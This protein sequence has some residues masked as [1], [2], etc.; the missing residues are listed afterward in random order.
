M[1]NYVNI[2]KIMNAGCGVGAAHVGIPMQVYRITDASNGDFLSD[3]N[4]LFQVF[5]DRAKMKRQDPAFE[6]AERM[7]TFWFELLINANPLNV[8]DILISTDPYLNAGSVVINGATDQYIG[9]CLAA[10][11][12][13][14]HAIAARL[15]INATLYRPSITPTPTDIGAGDLPYFDSTLPV[16]LPIVCINGQ[17]QL[18]VLTDTAS[19]IP[20]GT[21]PMNNFGAIFHNS[22][23][24]MPTQERRRVYV[25]PLPGFIP[26][27]GD[28]LVT[29]QGSRYVLLSNY[30]QQVGT[31]GGQ[32]LLEKELSGG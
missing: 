11:P 8:G 27:A 25:P 2:T 15:D 29:E 24:N 18:G 9:F 19:T 28:K 21:M 4:K 16:E 12:P 32:Y 3:G 17:F 26:K 7:E 1:S 5:C 6:S 20:I 22:T 23:P 14:K 31:V 30:E 13:I 10:L